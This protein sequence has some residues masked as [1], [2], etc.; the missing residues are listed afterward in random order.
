[1][2]DKQ[3]IRNELKKVTFLPFNVSLN[4]AGGA[5]ILDAIKEANLPVSTSCGG[6][7]TCGDCIVRVVEGRYS[8]KASAALAESLYRQGYVLACKTQVTD[9]LIVQLPRFRQLHVK[10][11]TDIGIFEA[12]RKFI[13]GS[14]EFEP[15]VK[16]L[17]ISVPLPTEENK[18]SDLKRLQQLLANEFGII[19]AGC[20]YNII[21]S[22]PHVLRDNQGDVTLVLYR[23][24]ESWKIVD[25][26]CGHNRK[27]IYGISCDIGTTTLVTGLVDLA[28]GRLVNAVSGFNQQIKC[29]ED[30][31]SRINYAERSGGLTEL[32]RLI[33]EEINNLIRKAAE[34]AGVAPDDIYY[35]AFSGNTTM[36]HLL[37]NI[38]PRYIRIDPY[39][40]AVNNV[41]SIS[42]VHLGLNINN[43]GIIHISPM[44]GS[45]VGGDITAGLLCTPLLKS[46]GKISL[47]IDIGTNGE[48]VIGNKDWLV[49]CA[50]SAGPAFEGG[51][52]KYGMPASDGAIES[53]TF[54]DIYNVR[55]KVIGGQKPRGICGSGLVDVLAGL[56]INGYIERNGSINKEKAKDRYIHD[57]TGKG[58][59]MVDAGRCYW[60][61]DIIIYEN[62]I[63]N[64][65][66]SK[67]AIYSACSLLLKNIG[68]TF[69]SIDSFFISGGFGKNINIENAVIIG[70]FPDIKRS[71]YHYLGNTSFYGTCLI[72]RSDRNRNLVSKAS[73]MMT[74]IELNNEPGYM[75]EYS[76]ALFLPH[77]NTGLFPSVAV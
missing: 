64:L 73:E 44:V 51:Q 69:E 34:R 65:I 25:A 46:K 19:D 18:Y 43:A 2:S 60:G 24:G 33:I 28:D 13:S 49:T 7:G 71:A 35:A 67:A 15:P 56:F 8:M 53:F 59:I 12:N 62:D 20:E 6:K 1:L 76:A 37:M 68:I 50:C 27:N 48:L 29:G 39:V 23:S 10:A 17:E 21:K 36:T 41:P 40:P 58:L 57:D 77:T 11:I 32:N 47:F 55:Y 45:Y 52:I 5:S 61:R 26:L 30:I 31:I 70:L 63:A 16:K 4:I 54:T 72:Q 22:L 42:P 3:K 74:Y 38:D 66:R 75:N 9:N 14:F